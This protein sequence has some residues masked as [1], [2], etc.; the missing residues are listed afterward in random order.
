MCQVRGE[1]QTGYEGQ[2]AVRQGRYRSI[3]EDEEWNVLAGMTDYEE[4]V[5]LYSFG[6]R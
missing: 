5:K 2:K 3:L 6:L 4:A 1:L